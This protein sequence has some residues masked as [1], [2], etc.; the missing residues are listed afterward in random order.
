MIGESSGDAGSRNILYP[1]QAHGV[2]IE[3]TTTHSTTHD[4]M[5]LL[6]VFAI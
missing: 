6:A 4:S 2:F 3:R 1:R 5:S